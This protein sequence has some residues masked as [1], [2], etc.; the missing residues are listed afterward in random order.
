MFSDLLMFSEKINIV[1]IL[2]YKFIELIILLHTFVVISYAWYKE[3]I[4]SLALFSN[5]SD[6]LPVLLVELLLVIF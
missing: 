2:F 3:Y 1:S 5:F 6:E 4:I